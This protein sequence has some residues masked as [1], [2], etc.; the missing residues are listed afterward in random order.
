MKKGS[1]EP[2]TASEAFDRHNKILQHLA[3]LPKKIVML[4]GVDNVSEFVLHEL[5]HENCFNL[6]KAAFFMDSPDF[7]VLKGVAGFSKLEAYGDPVW[8]DPKL[9]SKHMQQSSFNQMVKQF[10]QSS[11]SRSKADPKEAL[12]LIAQ[13]FDFNNAAF[14]S[15]Q[16]KHMNN[17]HLIYE[18]ED[19]FDNLH[20]H[21]GNSLY[22]LSFCP[23]F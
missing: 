19:H 21:F 1:V 7:D 20:E 10:A 14:H 11:I 4:D 9:F 6:E 8:D 18:F 5:C 22:L 3:D 17:G 15:L 12:A 13:Q 16:L 2:V 23:I